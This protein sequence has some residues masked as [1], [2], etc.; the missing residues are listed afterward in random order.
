VAHNLFANIF[1][2]VLVECF[3]PY[4][5]TKEDQGADEDNEDKPKS[6]F[7]REDL[8]KDPLDEKD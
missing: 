2:L 7:E 1:I 6:I 4:T 8:F 3:K 5:D